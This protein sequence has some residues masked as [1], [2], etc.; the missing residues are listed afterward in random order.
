MMRKFPRWLLKA[1]LICVALGL[2]GVCLVFGID[3]FVRGTTRD[4]ILTEAEAAQLS[5]IDCIIV[6]G[7]KVSSDGTLSHMLED[8]LKRGIALY[9]LDA[10]PK[11]LMYGGGEAVA[12]FLSE[13]SVATHGKPPEEN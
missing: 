2:L 13:K 10:A 8:R 12:Q 11:L 1:F 5:D 3:A 7:C 9:H 6:L 4:R